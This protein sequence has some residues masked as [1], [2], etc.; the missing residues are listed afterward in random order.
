MV[1]VAVEGGLQSQR[2]LLVLPLMMVEEGVEVDLVMVALQADLVLDRLVP[3][4]LEV[5]ATD[6]VR[7]S[8]VTMRR[9]L[10]V[11]NHAIKCHQLLS[12]TRLVCL[13]QEVSNVK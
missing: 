10:P 6:A 12:A 13:R 3:V 7:V 4:A 1:P 2:P 11:V 8:S 9:T 5:L